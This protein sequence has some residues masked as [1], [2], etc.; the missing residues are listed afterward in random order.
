MW[1][2]ALIKKGKTDKLNYSNIKTFCSLK[3]AIFYGKVQ[4]REG[5]F[6]PIK[7]LLSTIYENNRVVRKRQN[8]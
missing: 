4:S 8:T 6:S 7:G 1:S 3:D 5:I 2:K